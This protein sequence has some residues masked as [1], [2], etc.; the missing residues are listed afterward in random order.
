MALVFVLLP[1]PAVRADDKAE[2]KSSI[3]KT[4]WQ[5]VNEGIQLV[6]TVE[7]HNETGDTYVYYKP[8]INDHGTVYFYT[9]DGKR[10]SKLTGLVSPSR[11][12]VDEKNVGR[13]VSGQKLKL[14]IRVP[15]EY[16]NDESGLFLSRSVDGRETRLPLGAPVQVMQVTNTGLILALKEV[17]GRAIPFRASLKAREKELKNQRTPKVALKTPSASQLTLWGITPVANADPSAKNLGTGVLNKSRETE[18]F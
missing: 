18:L 1:S 13:L 17:S 3:R 7:L 10:I 2:L 11:F 15:F 12:F 8:R 4:E 9:L 16:R 14:E 5:N 6:L